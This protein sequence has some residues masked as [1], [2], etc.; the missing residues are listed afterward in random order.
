MKEEPDE[1]VA[2]HTE[3]DAAEEE[4][5][6]FQ[7]FQYSLVGQTIA[8]V[9]V[10]SRNVETDAGHAHRDNAKYSANDGNGRQRHNVAKSVSG[11]LQ[12][13]EE[14]SEAEV[15][16]DDPPEHEPDGHSQLDRSLETAG[17]A[18]CHLGQVFPPTELLR[19]H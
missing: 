11:E 2:H 12:V 16:V 6:V 15:V 9:F 5:N 13:N 14:T 19:F 1:C 7:D 8:E 18:V 3:D 4:R 10:R 17:D